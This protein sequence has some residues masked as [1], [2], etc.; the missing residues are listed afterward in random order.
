MRNVLFSVSKGINYDI[1]RKNKWVKNMFMKKKEDGLDYKKVNEGIRVGV[2][3]LKITLFLTIVLLTYVSLK[4]I[5]ELKVFPILGKLLKIISPF[6]IGIV[7]AWLFDPVVKSLEKRKVSRPLGVVFVY[8]LFIAFIALLLYIMIPM[9]GNQ[10]NDLITSAP[11]FFNE[12]KDWADGIFDGL[13]KSTGNDFIDIQ[14]KFYESINKIGNSFTVGLP[15][16]LMG[17]ISS[18]LQ[19]GLN[20]LIGLLIGFY[21]LFDFGNVKGHLFSL[22]PKKY[23]EDTIDLV[24]Q[25]NNNLRSYVAGTLRIMFIL[26]AFQSVALGIAGLKAPM[27][28]GLFC[29]V[30]NVIPYVGPYIG[31]IPAVLVGFSMDPMTGIC[32]LIAVVVAQVLE[33]YFLQPLVMGKTMKLHP[34]T[35][36]IGLLVFGSFFGIVGMI[37]A[38][39]VISIIKTIAIFFDEKFSL[40]ERIT[41]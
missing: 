31:G 15:A 3:L 10:L 25:L 26:F 1:I 17:I 18:I 6:F 32:S 16:Q 14:E 23:R 2:T 41:S 28:F 19:G 11:A 7:I 22:V 5:V 8:V 36:M 21:M 33:S 38:T 9:V 29:A 13:S 39:P 24:E 20:F 30:T 4:L 35:I 40:K 37:L 34:V 27:V 12:V